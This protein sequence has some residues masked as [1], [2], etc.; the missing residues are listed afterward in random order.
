MEA[1]WAL[2]T[3]MLLR[4][5]T[6][7]LVYLSHSRYRSQRPIYYIC[8]FKFGPLFSLYQFVA[9]HRGCNP[10][11]FSGEQSGLLSRLHLMV[12]VQWCKDETND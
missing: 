9:S 5:A 7:C 11:A 1:K 6:L 4:P 2:P 3:A 8:I 12:L 10:V